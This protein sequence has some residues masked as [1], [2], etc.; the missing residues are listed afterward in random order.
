MQTNIAQ[1]HRIVKT[2]KADTA[3]ILYAIRLKKDERLLSRYSH[4]DSVYG[5]RQVLTKAGK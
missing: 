3:E 2:W 1:L 5:W 4:G